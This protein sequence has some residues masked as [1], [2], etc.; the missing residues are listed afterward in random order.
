MDA[1]KYVYILMHGILIFNKKG[2][3]VYYVGSIF[4]D[5]LIPGT[6]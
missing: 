6:I 5:G 4:G 3:L 1:H 2:D